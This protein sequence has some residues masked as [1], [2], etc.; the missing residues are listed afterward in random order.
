MLVH[1]PVVF[2]SCAIAA[3][4]VGQ[5]AYVSVAADLAT[6]TL[7]LGC[8]SGLLALIAGVIDFL[9]VPKESPARD[10]AVSH[11][12]AM[13]SAWLIFL[14]ALALHGYPPKT[15]VPIAALI[16]SAAGFLVMAYGAWLGGKLVYEFGIG[17]A[18][19]TKGALK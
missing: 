7:A 9:D 16:A 3:D 19:A 8:A 15:P 1:F 11:L 13:C 4:V 2:W 5:F 10:T 6:G 14:V 12:M 18:P 17:A